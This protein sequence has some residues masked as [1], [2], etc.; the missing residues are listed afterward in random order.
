MMKRQLLKLWLLLCCCTA[1]AA[2]NPMIW[3]DLPDPDVIRVDDTFYLVS[4][5]MHMM[6][7]VPIM[8]SKDLINWEIAS[9]VCETLDGDDPLEGTLV[10]EDLICGTK[11]D[12]ITPYLFDGDVISGTDANG[13]ELFS[14]SY[15]Y[16]GDIDGVYADMVFENYFH[17][18]KADAEDAG[19]FTYFYLYR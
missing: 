7:A 18:Y 10:S 14:Y 19:I 17:A 2:D 3:A 16:E 9:Y 13:N 4:T 15:A 11:T 6:P 8:K 12:D 5:T 1:Q